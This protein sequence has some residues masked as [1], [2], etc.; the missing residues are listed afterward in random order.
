MKL[1]LL[2][3]FI[4][5]LLFC[6][7]A[8]SQAN[9]KA[10][11]SG[12]V[13]TFNQYEQYLK[14]SVEGVFPPVIA[15]KNILEK[16]FND[17]M[18]YVL[19]KMSI[20]TSDNPD[21]KITVIPFSLE[22]QSGNKYSYDTIN[23]GASYVLVNLFKFPPSGDTLMI[24]TELMAWQ[25]KENY[26]MAKTIFSSISGLDLLAPEVMTYID[27]SLKLI[28][29]LFPA[30]KSKD[31]VHDN[32]AKEDLT[33][34]DYKVLS[35]FN[36]E[37]KELLQLKFKAL[38]PIFT[39]C[40]FEPAYNLKYLSDMEAWRKALRRSA[41]ES[42]ASNSPEAVRSVMLAFSDYINT[43]PLVKK[44][45]TLFAA[46]ALHTWVKNSV[47]NCIGDGCISAG[48]FQEMPVGDLMYIRPKNKC[49]D[50]S[51]VVCIAPPCIAMSDFLRKSKTQSGR[52]ENAVKF[53]DSDFSLYLDG[54]LVA[55]IDINDYKSN[56]IIKRVSTFDT[57]SD[58]MELVYEFQE[59]ELDLRCRKDETAN[60]VSYRDKRILIYQYSTE[61]KY[62]ISQI[63]MF[64]VD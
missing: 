27:V 63:E 3:S 59:G 13:L 35:N 45:K 15:D 60:F 6:G 51:G 10:V 46:G 19:C 18:D 64:T 2:F 23:P 57:S 31:S 44:D 20:Y 9:L 58:G 43:K 36:G 1:K 47:K 5:I 28:E 50:F 22:R 26:A 34:T 40:N 30:K 16:I 4:F 37:E 25:G 62:Y 54:Q 53:I 39:G 41:E 52:N 42:I 48:L 14:I 12:S 17:K 56:F 29:K 8:Y 7:N 24:D 11:F 33:S 55:D 38:D 61:G 21:N 32:F 49:W